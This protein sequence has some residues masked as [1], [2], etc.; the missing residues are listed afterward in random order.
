MRAAS[1]RAGRVARRYDVS[2]LKEPYR[3][4]GKKTLAYEVA[5]QMDWRWPDWFIY[6]TGGGTGMVGMWKAFEELE[7][8][9]WMSGHRRPRMV[10]VQAEGV[11]ADRP[12]VSRRCVTM[13]PRGRA[14]DHRR[15]AARAEGDR[16]LSDPSR[17]ARERRD[18][19]HR[20]RRRDGGRHAALG[21][22]EGISAA[23]EG[24]ATVAALAQALRDG[25]MKPTDPSC[26]STPEARS[27]I[28]MC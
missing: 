6:P 18:R 26:C 10:S 7:R 24:G 1:P 3:I 13:R 22:L 9:G 15:R 5:E 14:D 25:T 19:A 8:I 20:V 17:R 12:R 11:R 27:S 28:W 21:A 2:T 16:R 23:P 4:E